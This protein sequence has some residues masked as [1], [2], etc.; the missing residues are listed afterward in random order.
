[1][2]S[3]DERSVNAFEKLLKL[4]WIRDSIVTQ[5]N[6]RFSIM[7]NLSAISIVWFDLSDSS[8]VWEWYAVESSMIVLR[9]LNIVIQNSDRNLRSRSDIISSDISQSNTSK[10]FISASAHWVVDQIISSDMIVSRFDVLHVTVRTKFV[11][12]ERVTMKFMISFLND[13]VETRIEI[14]F[15]YEK[16]FFVWLSWHDEQCLM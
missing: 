9:R 1:M 10:R 3:F 7:K 8:S 5:S 4:A 16:C 14:D 13:N 12:S 11:T 2:I 15:S 6:V